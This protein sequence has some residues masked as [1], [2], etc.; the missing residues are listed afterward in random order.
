[1][2][3]PSDHRAMRGARSRPDGSETVTARRRARKPAP[4]LVVLA[5]DAGRVA[6]HYARHGRTLC[7]LDVPQAEPVDVGRVTCGPCVRLARRWG[8][9]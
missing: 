5:V 7:G 4:L 1:M 3:P 2:A 8:G 9:S 6:A